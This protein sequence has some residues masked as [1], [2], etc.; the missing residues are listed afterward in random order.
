MWPVRQDKE[1]IA[2]TEAKL[3]LCAFTSPLRELAKKKWEHSQVKKCRAPLLYQE[4]FK[5]NQRSGG[6][7]VYSPTRNK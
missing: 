6:L 5:C 2:T 4:Q 3:K 7:N 1:K